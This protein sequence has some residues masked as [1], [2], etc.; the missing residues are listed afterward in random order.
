MKKL[1][2]AIIGQGRSGRDIHGKYFK[3][4]DNDKFNVVAV[5]DWLE[6]RRERAAKEYN[7][8]VFE[9]YTDLFALRDKIDLVVN[10]SYSK[11]H[12]SVT[13]DLLQNGFSV[14]C[15]KPFSATVS[16]CEE[17]INLAKEN[18]QHLFV[19]HQSLYTPS[20][21]GVKD[22]YNSGILG[23]ISAVNFRYSGLMRRWDWQTLQCEVA[24]SLY[25][26]G[27]H[28]IGQALSL[29]DWD[30]NTKLQYADLGLFNTS[31]DA[32]DYA[33]LI[34]KAPQK[35]TVDIEIAST[36][37][38]TGDLCADYTY[39]I[40]GQYGTLWA[41]DYKYTMTYIDPSSQ[42]DKPLIRESLFSEN[43]LPDYCHEDVTL[44]KKEGTFEGSAFDTAVQIYYDAAYDEIVNGNP[45]PVTP[46]MATK[47]IDIIEQSHKLCPLEKK[48]D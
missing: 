43:G 25:N 31:G 46:E 5:V 38:R 33:K 39:K 37:A 2:I 19:F 18:N 1:N 23:K 24:G 34:L 30:N 10:A 4:T 11:Y 12:Y 42:Q 32:E 13:K 3:S 9:N 29:L 26:S 48:F 17:L 6:V 47:V 45:H 8:E 36:D 22:I 14:L 15:E 7:C 44:L 21:C 40:Q 20:F 28:P 16:Q 27:P 41:N 35:P